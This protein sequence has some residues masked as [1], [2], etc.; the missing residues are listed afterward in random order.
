MIRTIRV[1]SNPM[2]KG[3]DNGTLVLSVG[4][5][6]YANC[7]ISSIENPREHYYEVYIRNS[8]SEEASLWQTF[9]DCPVN[10]IREP[11]EQDLS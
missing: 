3:K 4:Q 9:E 10:T 7:E 6:A 5:P 8:N 11:L 1:G 2:S